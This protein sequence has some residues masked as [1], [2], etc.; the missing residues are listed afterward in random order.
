MADRALEPTVQY[1]HHGE[2]QTIVQIFLL[3]KLLTEARN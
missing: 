2:Y 1:R 3:P